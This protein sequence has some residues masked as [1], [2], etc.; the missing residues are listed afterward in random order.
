M[1]SMWDSARMQRNRGGFNPAARSEITANVEQYL[2][3][4]D[5]IVNPRNFHRFRM[6]IEQARRERAD[7]VTANLKRLMD[8]RWLVNRAGNR[9]EIL[10]VERERINVAIPANDIERM[11][12]HRH[13]RPARSVLHQDLGIFF[14][15]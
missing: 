10:G 9:L 11:M 6:G 2:I 14:L 12:R 1:R 7:N 13:A 8:G 15:V 5:I 4:F 3:C